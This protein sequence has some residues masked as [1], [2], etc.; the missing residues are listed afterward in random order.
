[1]SSLAPPPSAAAPLS[2]LAAGASDPGRERDE[3]E[4]AFG[5]FP[6]ARLYV[7][8]DGMGGRAGG[9]TAARTAVEEVERFFR[10]HHASPRS[11][12]PFPI[13]KALSLGCN[14]Q[15]VGM[16]VAN[17]KIRE[18]ASSRPELNRMGATVAALAV[19]ET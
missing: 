7:V 18:T 10:E 1:M 17:Q 12:W 9:G 8:A 2:L 4:D 16:Q 5:L 3:N 14:L 11:P 15:R 6:K 13:D 19:G